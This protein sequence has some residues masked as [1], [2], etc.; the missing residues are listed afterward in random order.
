M[1]N[2]AMQNGASDDSPFIRP[3]SRHSKLTIVDSMND[4]SVD[5]KLIEMARQYLLFSKRE[6]GLSENTVEAYRSD[7]SGFIFWLP[8]NT[9]SIDRTLVSRYMSFLKSSGCQPATLARALA[10]LRGWFLWQQAS[11]NLHL[12][13]SDG[14]INPKR[15]KKLPVVLTPK[16]VE[17]IIQATMSN[18]RERAMIELLYGAGLRVSEL[19]GLEIKDVN[20]THGYVR[21]VGKGNKERLVPIGKRAVAAVRDYLTERQ[22]SLPQAPTAGKSG[23]GASS[24]QNQN[25][26]Q[27]RMPEKSPPLFVDRLGGK[28]NRLV[29]WQVVKRLAKRAK[30]RKT[31]SPHTLRHSFATHLLENG[32]DLR[33][34]QEL[35]GHAS[36]VTTQ[37]YTHISRQHLRKAYDN[38]QLSIHDLAFTREAESLGLGKD[39]K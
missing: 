11:G 9:T 19:S 35:L 5:S 18:R 3:A 39:E 10:S 28:C 16:E 34:V 20:L 4:T 32:A 24:Q 15:A 26:K 22:P 23:R 2:S 33:A 31:L 38:A 8:P 1:Y 25:R 36:I 7:L 17:A 37:L 21:C 13:P 29:I 30:I 27:G 14:V 12:D 6:R